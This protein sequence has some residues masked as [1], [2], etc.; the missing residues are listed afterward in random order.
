MLRHLLNDY[1][2]AIDWNVQNVLKCILKFFSMS[3]DN[4]YVF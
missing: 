3:M 4:G 1:F 2:N